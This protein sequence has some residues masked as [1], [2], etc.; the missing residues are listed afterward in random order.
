MSA[1]VLADLRRRG[2]RLIVDGDRLRLDAPRG[3]LSLAEVEGLRRE[4]AALLE[5]IRAEEIA[6][7]APRAGRSGELVIPFGADPRFRWWE[8]N[9][10]EEMRRRFRAAREAAGLP[11]RR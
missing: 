1:P 2:V 10:D 9:T 4:K 11:R 5:A 7:A 6:R 8:A 3:V